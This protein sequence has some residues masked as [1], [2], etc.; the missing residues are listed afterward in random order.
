[1]NYVKKNFN[2]YDRVKITNLPEND[3]LNN[4]LGTLVGCSFVS[5]I[6]HYIVI[7]DEEVEQFD[8]IKNE[9]SRWRAISITE[10]YLEKV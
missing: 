8:Y 5:H 7:M 4:K 3:E 1:M 6:N 2:C 9:S 10:V